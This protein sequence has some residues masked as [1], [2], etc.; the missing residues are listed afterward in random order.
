MPR[1]SVRC[2]NREVGIVTAADSREA[3]E[4][5]YG[6][7]Q[8][9]PR[10][11]MSL[12]TLPEGIGPP[13]HI[14]I[15]TTNGRALARHESYRALCALH[16]IQFANVDAL[17][18]RCGTNRAYGP[19]SREQVES[20]L[21]YAGVTEYPPEYSDQIKALRAALEDA[22]WLLLPFDTKELDWQAYAVN[23]Q[24]DRPLAYN[25]HGDLPMLVQTWSA[26]PQVNRKRIDSSF[27]VNF[28]SGN[29]SGESRPV[30][31]PE[32]SAGGRVRKRNSPP[33]SPQEDTT[34]ATAKKA[35]KKTAAK[36]TAPAKKT[37]AA[38]AKKSTTGPVDEKNGVKRP[39][40]GGNTAQVWDACDALHAKKGS[41]PTFKEV[42]EY[43][44]K[45][46]AD[47]PTATRR[48]NY[49]V[50]RKYNGITGRVS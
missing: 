6:L 46:N 35:T 47:I 14:L 21:R 9:S 38:P 16:Y 32:A 12:L 23:P 13:M 41:A 40:P 45:K 17:I 4:L 26:E 33:T 1:Y 48:S 29:P 22:P 27:W 28:A 7:R 20:C 37:P 42:D 2:D 43:I 24:D 3:I 8:W 5:A 11:A 18:I 19:L 44:E 15:D 10:E 39:K 36:K 34:M 30:E 50:W 49:A 31:L 25:P